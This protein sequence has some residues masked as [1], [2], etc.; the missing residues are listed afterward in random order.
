MKPAPPQTSSF[1]RPPPTRA[2]WACR[3]SARPGARARRRASRAEH[4][5]RRAR[6]RAA[7]VGGACCGST[8]AR[9]APVVLE[10][11]DAR[12]RTTSSAPPPATC[13]T[14]VRRALGDLDERAARGGRCRSGSRPGRRRPRARRARRRGA[15]SCRRS[16]CRAGRTARSVRTIAMRPAGGLGDGVLARELGAPVGADAGRSGAASAY[17]SVA[18]PSNDV[19]AS[20]RGRR[21]RRPRP[22]RRRRVRRRAPLTRGRVRL[23]GPRRRRRRSRRRS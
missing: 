12:G 6:R 8:R 16:S 14:P 13:R 19:V 15:A 1:M 9:P 4:G 3:P 18:V 23:G 7:E 17:G 2:R 11:R 5:V 20:R 10:R 21:A 22:P